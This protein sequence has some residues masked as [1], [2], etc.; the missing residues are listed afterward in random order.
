VRI[1]IFILISLVVL[2]AV[3]FSYKYY[4]NRPKLNITTFY[5]CNGVVSSLDTFSTTNNSNNL[6]IIIGNGFSNDKLIITIDDSVV[7]N[8]NVCT[9]SST[10]IAE[11]IYLLDTNYYKM[12]FTL[13][14]GQSSNI[15]INPKYHFLIINK[16]N[17][18]LLLTYTNDILG[19][20]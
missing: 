14:S 6:S 9:E 5:R 15:A 16:T 11:E 3:F 8:K 4:N 13:N 12:L 2:I 17:Q 1:K 18:G 7:L 20:D 10:G 19:Y